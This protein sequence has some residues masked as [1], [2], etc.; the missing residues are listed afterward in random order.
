L[1]FL[2][3]GQTAASKADL[4]SGAR[5][6]A[7]LTA[8]GEEM[9]RLFGEAYR[10]SGFVAIHSSPQI[11]ALHTVR[12]VAAAAGLT[13]VAEAGLREIDYGVWDGKTRAEVESAYRDDYIRWSADPA[14][15]APT[16][17]ETAIAVAERARPVID[18]LRAKY[19]SGRVLIASHK[20][21]IRI[22]LCD[23]LG[24]ELSRFRD[25][26]AAP[27]GSVSVVEFGNRGPLLTLLGDRSFQS[28]RLRALPGT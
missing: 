12:H 3:H 13:P 2:R 11:R 7:D 9:A 22:I 28:E 5:V 8:D 20:A 26:L 1:Y 15:N 21:T 27:V 6:D 16:G 25:R 10:S 18:R 19:A 4:F 23:L 14:W 17:G 24:I